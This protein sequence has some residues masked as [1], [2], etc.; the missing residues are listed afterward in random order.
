MTVAAT[1]GSDP[2]DG[3]PGRQDASF[4]VLI[5]GT[6]DARW[7]IEQISSDLSEPL[8]CAPD[9]L[10]GQSIVGLVHPDDADAWNLLAARSAECPGGAS[11]QVRFLS[12]AC[13]WIWCRIV[14]QRLPGRHPVAYAFAMSAPPRGA[15]RQDRARDLEEHLRRIAREVSASGVVSLSAPVPTALEAPEL[16]ELTSREYE[17]VVRL[18]KGERVPMIARRLFL[19]QST[20]RNHLTS[21]Y[22]KFGVGSQ[23]DLLSHLHAITKAPGVS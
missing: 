7:R 13:D 9:T 15:R 1:C 16:E 5:L 12:V 23:I 11:A 3:A 18:A 22:R 20:V 2:P 10:V 6:V 4:P 8:G 14:L 19:S 17:I 21:V